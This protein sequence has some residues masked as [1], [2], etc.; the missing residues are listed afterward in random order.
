MTISSHP[1]AGRPTTDRPDIA[2]LDS[3]ITTLEEVIREA[4]DAAIA[5]RRRETDLARLRS[6]T[7]TAGIPDRYKRFTD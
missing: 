1:H 3:A 7:P 6:S 5:A 4:E 2:R